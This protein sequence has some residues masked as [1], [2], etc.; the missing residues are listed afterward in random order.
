MGKRKKPWRT[1]AKQQNFEFDLGTISSVFDKKLA[2]LKLFDHRNPEGV[3]LRLSNGYTLQADR[4]TN[5]L[6]VTQRPQL[7]RQYRL[8]LT[9]E[10]CDFFVTNEGK[11]IGTGDIRDIRTNS[12]NP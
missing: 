9:H 12:I 10:N 4:T 2:T 6:H 8:N 7:T 11:G 3:L 5:I 1:L